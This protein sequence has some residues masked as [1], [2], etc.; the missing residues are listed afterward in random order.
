[1]LARLENSHYHLVVEHFLISVYTAKQNICSINN[2]ELM[3]TYVSGNL[4]DS[5]A[6][7]LVN[8]VNT[9]G[10]MGKGIAKE[11]KQIY[12]EIFAEY[13]ELCE[14]GEFTIGTLWLYQTSHKWILNFPT[15]EHWRQ[16][17]QV[18]YVEAGLQ[19]FVSSYATRG[20][21][22][23]AF[24]ALGCGNGELDFDSQVRP[25]MEDYLSD[26]P[27]EIF[28]YL[29]DSDPFVEHR[30]PKEFRE[31]LRKEPASL[32]FTEVWDDII[33]LVK[34]KRNFETAKNESQFTAEHIT[35]PE[36][37]IRFESSAGRSRIIY[38]DTFLQIW[39]QIRI[40][41]YSKREMTSV[42]HSDMMF[43]IG[44]LQELPYIRLVKIAD[45]YSKWAVGLQYHPIG[46]QESKQVVQLSLV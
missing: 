6:Q 21:H 12:P 33:E 41:G 2:G 31:W 23:I 26:L 3:I 4:F 15:K 22:S 32:A 16:P 18:E 5:P 43:V 38:K 30:A 14:R 28:I 10:V 8:T 45:T 20:I 9:V 40:L 1:M 42:R 34:R 27:I 39:Q 24:P 37:G 25:L 19:K 36:E 44:L 7:V 35:D 17:S 11:F 46:I 13:Q 29:Y